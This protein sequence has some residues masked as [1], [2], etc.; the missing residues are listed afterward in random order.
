M[1]KY[2]VIPLFIFFFLACQDDEQPAQP[3]HNC[4]NLAPIDFDTLVYDPTTY[5]LNIPPVLPENRLTLPS[6]NELTLEGVELGRQLFYDPILSLDYTVSCASCHNPSFSFTDDGRQF[7][8]GVNDAIGNRNAMALIDLAFSNRFFWD[9]ST[10]SL[11]EQALAPVPNPHEMNLDWEE[12]V[13][14]LM[15]NANYRQQFYTTFGKKN[16]TKEMVA[17]SLAQFERTLIS[18]GLSK[19]DLHNT[20]G[21]GVSFT[22]AE[23]RGFE[24]FNT[25]KADCFH[26]HT[27]ETHLFTDFDFH[28]NGLDAVN[29]VEDFE[30][31][32]LGKHTG[33]PLDHGKFKTPTLRNIAL[34]APYMHDGRFQ[35]LEE[36]V[37]H[38]SDGIKNSPTLD[39]IIHTKF[40]EG[41]QLTPSEKADLIAFLHTLTD[42]AF[43]NNPNFQNPFD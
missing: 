6:D 23:E 24:I 39:N 38:Y 28:N 30:D 11:E 14:R 27:V 42:T 8:K 17:K 18:S 40:Q 13:C 29:K 9:G 4:A 15:N 2:L 35:T 31:K 20:S 25:E 36:V 41:L 7:S 26:C 34:T 5:Q 12:A 37:D 21:T 19:Y 16:I 22:D 43:V 10:F 33:N 32:G 1:K 3:S